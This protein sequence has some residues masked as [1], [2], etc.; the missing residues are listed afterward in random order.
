MV[1][2][3]LPALQQVAQVAAVARIVRVAQ[4]VLLD[5]EMLA[6]MELAAQTTAQAVAVVQVQ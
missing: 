2:D 1:A 5:K 6:V 4:L 3:H